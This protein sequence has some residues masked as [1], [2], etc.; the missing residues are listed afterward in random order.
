MSGDDT[1]SIVLDTFL[2]RPHRLPLRGQRRRRAARRTHL[3][4][5]PRRL[6][7]LG[8]DLGR[9][10]RRTRERVDGGDRTSRADDSFQPLERR[11]GLQ[12]PAL[13]RAGSDHPALERGDAR[14]EAHRP[15]PRR[16]PDG[17]GALEQGWGLTVSPFALG[18]YE[19]DHTTDHS[20]TKGQA[21]LD[22]GYHVTHSSTA[23]SRSIP[24]S[25]RSRPTPDRSTSPASRSSSRRS[26]RSS[27]RAPASSP[28]VWTSLDSLHSVLLAQGRPVRR[29]DHPDHG[30]SEGRRPRRAL[31][32]GRPGRRRRATRMACRGRTW[33]RDASR[34]T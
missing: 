34:T 13:R 12:H 7:R 23:S 19:L 18:R 33:R 1:V 26:A 3:G 16:D 8:R 22:L 15:A 25:R 17:V 14:R 2:D 31:G 11:V 6:A 29:P 32:R 4:P 30:G 20:F 5:Q 9:R 28:S 21:G 27:P 10:T 24:T